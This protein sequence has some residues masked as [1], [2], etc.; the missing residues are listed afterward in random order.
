MFSFVGRV[1][2]KPTKTDIA[3]S[4]LMNMIRFSLVLLF[5]LMFCSRG[6]TFRI[7]PLL[8]SSRLSLAALSMSSS[9]EEMPKS[10]K[11]YYYNFAF[12]RAE[13]LRAGMFLQGIP[14]EN[15]TDRD[16]LNDLKSKGLCAFGAFPVMEIDGKFLSQTQA[17][18]AYVGKL[19]NMY[20]KGDI[21]AQA[22]CDEI[23]N[24]CTDVTTTIGSTFSTPKDEVKE[25]REK[26][27]D[28]ESGR[29]YKHLKG[30]NSVVCQDGSEFACGK[31]HGLTVADLAVWRLLKWF[32]SGKLDYIPVDVVTPFKNLQAIHDNVEKNEKIQ[33]YL[34]EYYPEK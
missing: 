14:F 34:K 6:A 4:P 13:M 27:I 11:L 9:K 3:V 18:A 19:G 28:P 20:P 12:W 7:N 15:V 22:N 29:L 30:L 24:G 32:T 16:T 2:H 21:L 5:V 17:C 25:A 8:S 31:E 23:I 1:G 26:L 10:I 33:E